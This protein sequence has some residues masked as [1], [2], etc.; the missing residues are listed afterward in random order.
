MHK[1]TGHFDENLME[2]KGGVCCGLVAPGGPVSPK[3]VGLKKRFSKI[4]Q[5]K[6]VISTIIIKGCARYGLQGWHQARTGRLAGLPQI[7]R[8]KKPIIEKS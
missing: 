6:N 2:W 7:C 4:E 1:I 5:F 8:T 3:S